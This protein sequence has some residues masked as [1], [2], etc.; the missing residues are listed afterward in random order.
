MLD[1]RKII[2]F[3]LHVKCNFSRHMYVNMLLYVKK[4]K[5][6][7]YICIYAYIYTYT[8]TY[9]HTYTIHLYIYT[10]IYMSDENRGPAKRRDRE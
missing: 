10:H 2:N 1:V 3:L 9:I 7:Y 8:H 6:I 5:C 4:Y